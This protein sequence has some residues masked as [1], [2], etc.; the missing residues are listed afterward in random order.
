[1][2]SL[3]TH[4]EAALMEFNIPFNNILQNSNFMFIMPLNYI[5]ITSLCHFG[6]IGFRFKPQMAN[7][8]WDISKQ[9]S[10]RSDAA[11]K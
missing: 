8:L 5:T 7:I 4:K 10:P 11:K 1:M 3:Y 2:V 9:H 6:H